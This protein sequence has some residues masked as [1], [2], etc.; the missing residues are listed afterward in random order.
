MEERRS[1]L[2]N[3]KMCENKVVC[4]YFEKWKMLIGSVPEIL[5]WNNQQILGMFRRRA[6]A[7]NVRF[8]NSLQWTIY[9]NKI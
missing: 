1:E 7:R 8:R 3:E 6:N 9:I 2:E 4:G 5:K